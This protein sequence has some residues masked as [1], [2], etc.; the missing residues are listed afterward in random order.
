MIARQS[1]HAARNASAFDLSSYKSATSL[2]RVP[3]AVEEVSAKRPK[4]ESIRFRAVIEE[5]LNDE[6]RDRN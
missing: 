3:N 6:I 5:D 2:I 1:F 4:K